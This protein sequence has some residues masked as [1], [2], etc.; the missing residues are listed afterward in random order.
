MLK[1]KKDKGN[2]MQINSLSILAFSSRTKKIRQ[3][4]N[5]HP[6]QV[7]PRPLSYRNAKLTLPSNNAYKTASFYELQQLM[8]Q[9]GITPQQLVETTLSGVTKVRM[10]TSTYP[11]YVGQGTAHT[12]YRIPINGLSG[13]ALR[14]RRNLENSILGSNHTKLMPVTLPFTDASNLASPIAEVVFRADS[15]FPQCANI[16]RFLPGQSLADGCKKSNLFNTNKIIRQLQKLSRVPQHKFNDFLKLTNSLAPSFSKL[17]LRLRNLLILPN[18][19]IGILDYYEYPIG[20]GDIKQSI[21]PEIQTFCFD[22][23]VFSSSRLL[24][25][26]NEKAK[27]YTNRIKGKLEEAKLKLGFD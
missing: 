27:K 21:W 14:I 15:Y 12:A 26:F 23:D 18:K 8:S 24:H 13:Y 4:P 2:L 25:P 6:E 3:I 10:C 1:L 19:D 17:D 22:L 20:Q 5:Q 11:N 7:R 9:R 16:I